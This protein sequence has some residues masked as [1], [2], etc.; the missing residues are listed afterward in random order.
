MT[1]KIK[2]TITVIL[3]PL[4]LLF[5]YTLTAFAAEKPN[6]NTSK[7]TAEECL[8]QGGAGEIMKIISV[9]VNFLAAAV[10]VLAVILIILAG[11][12]YTTSNGDPQKVAEAKKRIYN[13]ILG[14]FAF[15]FLY[16]FLQWLIPGNISIWV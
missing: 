2:L 10:F 13:V 3:T 9:G 1:T 4:I 12:Q 11:I 8:K 7:C 15:I 16:A 14:I 6:L 5:L